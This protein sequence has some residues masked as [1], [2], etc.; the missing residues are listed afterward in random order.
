MCKGEVYMKNKK[1]LKI[2]MGFIFL[3]LAVPTFAEKG[4]RPVA[5]KVVK[6]PVFNKTNSGI[7]K[8]KTPNTNVNKNSSA[9]KYDPNSLLKT[10]GQSEESFLVKK[11]YMEL[12]VN[13]KL[14][15]YI[16]K[17]KVYT[18]DMVLNKFVEIVKKII[19]GKEQIIKENRE[20]LRKMK[21][22]NGKKEVEQE[23]KK[24][25]KIQLTEYAN[26]LKYGFDMGLKNQMKKMGIEKL[27]DLSNE[28][29]KLIDEQKKQIENQAEI[30]KKQSKNYKSSEFKNFKE[31]ALKAMNDLE[32]IQKEEILLYSAF[33]GDENRLNKA[34]EKT[35]EVFEKNKNFGK[36][37]KEII[38]K[39]NVMEKKYGNKTKNKNFKK[40]KKVKNNV[41]K[42]K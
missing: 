36:L 13:R 40:R 24:A 25:Y 35:K 20:K 7:K 5:N 23:I 4:V 12:V 18:A 38:N 3:S 31:A 17:N 8:I 42:N 21:T 19:E 33:L 22:K 34:K 26:G 37:I 9:V 6:L 32:K 15:D 11:L 29:R 16:R 30:I 27:E 14:R 1:I 39:A 28:Q 2:L 41:S 10:V